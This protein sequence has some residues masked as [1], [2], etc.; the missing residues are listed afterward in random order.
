MT[1]RGWRTVF[2]RHLVDGLTVDERITRLEQRVAD[3]E[4]RRQRAGSVG[5]WGG[6]RMLGTYLVLVLIDRL[7]AR[8]H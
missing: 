6:L 1:R 5:V 2:D 7:H 3:C 4:L 8:K